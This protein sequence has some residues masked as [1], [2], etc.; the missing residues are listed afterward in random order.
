[1]HICDYSVCTTV[2]D[3]FTFYLF[4][5]NCNADKSH[6]EYIHKNIFLW[7]QWQNAATFLVQFFGPAMHIF[8]KALFKVINFFLGIFNFID[9]LRMTSYAFR[10]VIESDMA[11]KPG[12][13]GSKTFYLLT[14]YV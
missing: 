12:L 5:Q 14:C 3:V 9:V 1:M 6:T 7:I 13:V 8:L 2:I 11:I 10:N 4:A